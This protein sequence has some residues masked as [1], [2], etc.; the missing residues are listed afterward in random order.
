M[1]AVRVL[2][3]T[4]SVLVL[5]AAGCSGTS[6]DTT[7][8]DVTVTVSATGEPAPEPTGP[9]PTQS[10]QNKPSIEIASL[11]V[12]GVPEDGTRCNPISWLAGD[13]PSGVTLRLGTPTFDPPGIFEMDPSGCRPDVQSCPDLQWT[14]QNLPQCW[15]GFKQIGT[16]GTV[17]LIIPA[18]AICDTEDLCDTFRTLGGSQITLTAQPAETPSGN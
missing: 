12:G 14:A 6:G 15:V 16:E 11:P 9:E 18:T 5:A 2:A 7:P 10:Q 13:I 3:M 1:V 8:P 4:V 17:S